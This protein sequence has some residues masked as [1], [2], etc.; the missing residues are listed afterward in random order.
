MGLDD[1]MMIGKGEASCI[2]WVMLDRNLALGKLEDF[3]AVLDSKNGSLIAKLLQAEVHRQ[4]R[5][6]SRQIHKV[7]IIRGRYYSIFDCRDYVLC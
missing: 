1:T 4:R 3:D 5:N 2:N 6:L 7:P